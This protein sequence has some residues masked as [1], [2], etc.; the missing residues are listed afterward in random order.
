MTFIILHHVEA[1]GVRVY[2]HASIAV[3]ETQVNLTSSYGGT[4]NLASTNIL[5]CLSALSNESRLFIRSLP[6]GKGSEEGAELKVLVTL[7][8]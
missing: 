2:A 8:I 4:T 6:F 5:Y 7:R 1:R 3:L